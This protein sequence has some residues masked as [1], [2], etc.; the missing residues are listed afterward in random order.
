LDCVLASQVAG[1]GEGVQ[2]VAGQLVG[3]YVVAQVASV[4]CLGDQALDEVA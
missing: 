3:G 2:A 4:G 1:G